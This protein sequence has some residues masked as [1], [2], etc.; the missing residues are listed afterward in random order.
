M[1]KKI[2][3]SCNALGSLLCNIDLVAGVVFRR[4]PDVATIDAVL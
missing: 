1:L 4:V 3:C 2:D